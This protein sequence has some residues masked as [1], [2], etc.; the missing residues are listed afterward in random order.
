MGKKIKIKDLVVKEWKQEAVRSGQDK[1]EAW[2]EMVMV[3]VVRTVQICNQFL[4]LLV[5]KDSNSSKNY[6][7]YDNFFK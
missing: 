3:H 7:N 2:S 6:I 1:I 5:R 4:S